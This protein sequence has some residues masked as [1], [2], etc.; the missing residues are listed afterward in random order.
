MVSVR[1]IPIIVVAFAALSACNTTDAL[2]PRVGIGDDVASAP[3]TQRE[4]ERMAA[5]PHQ[6]TYG[7]Q[8]RD[9][10][11][12][13]YQQQGYSTTGSS[14][15]TLDEQA[16]ALRS[17]GRNPVASKP[18][19]DGMSQG[20]DDAENSLPSQSDEQREAERRLSDPQ[21]AQ[22]QQ[23][24]A[25]QSDQSDAGQQ[26]PDGEQQQASLPPAAASDGNTI[27][28]LPII[29]GPVEAVT[30]LSRQLGVEARAN[31]L[32][33][34]GSGDTAAAYILKG[35]LTTFA[36]GPQITVSYVWDVLDST[37]GRLHR[38][39]GTESVPLKRGDPWAAVPPS[40]MQK[41]A[42]KTIAEFNGWRQTR[43]A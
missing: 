11:Q 29:G 22:E 7:A 16:D 39:Q 18:L 5:A 34:K 27:R 35:Y 8:T 3:V 37:G 21:P 42:S 25:E 24:A 14:S 2:T 1:S 36:D 6:P 17:G 43:G 20:Q 10:Y 33:I 23:Q 41:I 38:I 26:Q 4:V 32:T 30:P 13:S 15:A 40:V 31:G 12:S 28:F 9:S 19:H